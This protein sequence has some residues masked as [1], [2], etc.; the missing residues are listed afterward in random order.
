[1]SEEADAL[2]RKRRVEDQTFRDP[3]VQRIQTIAPKNVLHPNPPP[4]QEEGIRIRKMRSPPNLS[5]AIVRLTSM[6]RKQG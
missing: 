2:V 1:M 6:A 3:E 4:T 5:A